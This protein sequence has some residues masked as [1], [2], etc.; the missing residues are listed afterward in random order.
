MPTRCPYSQPGAQCSGSVYTANTVGRSDKVR[1]RVA[2][3]REAS[4][5]QWDRRQHTPAPNCIPRL[6]SL[7]IPP[8]T[9]ADGQP[10]DG[11]GS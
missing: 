10:H 8:D 4:G 3:Q 2:G 7:S 9:E 6:G 5:V 1:N 11:R